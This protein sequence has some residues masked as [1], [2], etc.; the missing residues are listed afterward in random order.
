[1]HFILNGK[2][3]NYVHLATGPK[4]HLLM[5]DGTRY[6]FDVLRISLLDPPDPGN[7]L[8]EVEPLAYGSGKWMLGAKALS[9]LIDEVHIRALA[10]LNIAR[11]KKGFAPIDLRTFSEKALN[12]PEL[13][14]QNQSEREGGIVRRTNE[15]F[16]TPEYVR[17]WGLW[18]V[19]LAHGDKP[20]LQ[21]EISAAAW[22]E[23]NYTPVLL[24]HFHVESAPAAM[25]QMPPDYFVSLED[26]AKYADVTVRTIKNWRSCGWLQVEQRGRKFRIARSDLDKCRRQPER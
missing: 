8:I 15:K 23:G 26:A 21:R 20:E 22:F 5:A 1:M 16:F 2:L 19:I 12:A 18:Q 7:N 25:E 3:A 17:R 10:H 24:R 9:T 4:G 14:F 6:V 11:K 13:H